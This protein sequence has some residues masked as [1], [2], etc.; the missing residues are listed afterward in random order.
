MKK[1]RQRKKAEMY[2]LVE[3]WQSSGQSKLSFSKSQGVPIH[4]FH[5]WVRKY[6]KDQSGASPRQPS[7]NFVA[8]RLERS[9]IDMGSSVELTYPN[10]VKLRLTGPVNSMDLVTMIKLGTDV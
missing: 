10:G 4:T 5:Y 6:E 3:K 8:L 9:E 2:P 1:N 7:G